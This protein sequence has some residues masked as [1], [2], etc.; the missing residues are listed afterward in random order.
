MCI[1]SKEWYWK[2]KS[3]MKMQGNI[4]GKINFEK[5]IW[6]DEISDR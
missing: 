6:D 2:H 5:E 4:Y 1:E 3:Q